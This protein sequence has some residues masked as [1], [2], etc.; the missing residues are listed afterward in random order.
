MQL[1]AENLTQTLKIKDVQALLD[2]AGAVVLD[3]ANAQGHCMLYAVANALNA[4][5]RQIIWSKEAIL[6]QL[7]SEISQNSEIYSSYMPNMVS[8]VSAY[9][10]GVFQNEAADCTLPI[11]AKALD[12]KVFIIRETEGGLMSTLVQPNVNSSI[13]TQD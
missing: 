7:L 1:T 3:Q 4:A 9:V 6:H 5:K 11:L 8:T 10:A 13:Q 12:L 2:H